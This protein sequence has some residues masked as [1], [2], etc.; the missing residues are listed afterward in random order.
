[1]GSCRCKCGQRILIV[2]TIMAGIAHIYSYLPSTL[3]FNAAGSVVF[4][5]VTTVR[6]SRGI[7]RM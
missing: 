3:G 6:S 1:M 2:C 5:D 4:S 7:A